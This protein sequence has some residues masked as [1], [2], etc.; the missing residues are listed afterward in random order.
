M[1]ENRVEGTAR[2]LGGKVKKDLARLR[3]TCEHRLR[4]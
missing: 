3:A 2:N 4:G 1:D